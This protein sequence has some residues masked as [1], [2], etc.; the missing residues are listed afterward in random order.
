MRAPVSFFS[1]GRL[2]RLALL[3]PSLALAQGPLLPIP[4]PPDLQSASASALGAAADPA[5]PTALLGYQGIAVPQLSQAAPAPQLGTQDWRAANAA[6]GQ[7]PRGHADIVDW[8]AVQ[9]KGGSGATGAAQPAT[10]AAPMQHGGNPA[11]A[12]AAPPQGGAHPHAMH[13]KKGQP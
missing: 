7:F 11:M 12:P 1:A 5:A 9:A 4:Q 10:P 3:A 2:A 8:E 13:P 6:V